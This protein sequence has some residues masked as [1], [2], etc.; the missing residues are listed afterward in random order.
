MDLIIHHAK[1][2]GREGL[3]AIGVLD[4]VIARLEQTQ[5]GDG[6]LEGAQPAGGLTDHPGMAGSPSEAGRLSAADCMSAMGSL[7]TADIMSEADRVHWPEASSVFDAE[8]GLLLPGFVEPHIHLDKAE[9]LGRMPSDAGSLQE[10]IRMTAEMK[11]GFTREDIRQRSLSVLNRAIR[12]GVTHMRCHAEVDPILGLTAV[13]AALELKEQV[14]ELLDL[15]VVVFPQEGIMA[16]PGT[17]ELM[18]E[19]L[20]MGGDVVGGI[21]YQDGDAAAHIEHVFSLAQRYGKPLDFHVDFSD[22]PEQLD[23]LTIADRTIAAGMEGRVAAGHVTSLGSVPLEAA[24]RAA[25]LISRAGISVMCLPQTDLYLGGRGDKEHPR[26]GLTPVKLLQE[27]GVNVVIGVNNVRNPFTP[28]GT[29]DPLEAGWLLASTAYMGSD[30]DAR[31]VL[32]M[33]THGAAQAIGAEEYGVRLG[34][35]A[36]LVLLPSRDERSALLDR[37]ARRA[38]WKR[39]RLTAET[40]VQSYTYGLGRQAQGA[41][42]PERQAE[43]IYIQP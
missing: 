35:N 22:H 9:L 25:S 43:P 17:A 31:R 5:Q 19:A 14:R 13:E 4:G 15:Q 21:P 6:W 29:A 41:E 3:Y 24:A 30:E 36:D 34:A 2:P 11:R 28:F 39:G 26:R 8:G 10:A 33:L 16:S 23:I 7:N 1:L 12:S 40:I 20:R 42:M 38:V 27:H 37:P 32:H 18:E